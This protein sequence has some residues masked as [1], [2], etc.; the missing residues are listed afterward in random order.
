VPEGAVVGT[1]GSTGRSTG[2]HLH[3]EVRENGIA[4]NPANFVKENH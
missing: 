1:V 3:F 4:T 2:P